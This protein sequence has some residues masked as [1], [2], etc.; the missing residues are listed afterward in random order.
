MVAV[1]EHVWRFPPLDVRDLDGRER[2]LP[3]DLDGERTLVILAFEQRQQ[4]LVDSWVPWLEEQAAADPGL[5]F[6]EVPTIGTGWKP[7]RGWIDGGM[8]RGIPDPVVRRRTLTAYVPVGPI[9]AELGITDTGDIWIF[10]V[11]RAGCVRWRGRGGFSPNS[12]AD[13][14]RALDAE[15]AG[16]LSAGQA[17][18]AVFPFEF[19]ERYRLVLRGLGVPPANRQVVITPE[20]FV[21]RFGRWVVDTPLANVDDA[22]ITGPY[23]AHR[24]IGARG[25]FA[26]RGATFGTTCAGGVCVQFHTPVRG[27]DPLGLVKHPGFAVTVAD[28]E[29]LRELLRRRAGRGLAREPPAGRAAGRQPGFTAE[30]A[31]NQLQGFGPLA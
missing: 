22:C 2:R 13:L 28:R 14:A 29:G 11:D 15:R 5:R 17:A 12:A 18:V 8:R 30:P 27:L 31:V 19:E 20:R 21:A 6:V 7:V 25:S 10:L 9:T 4:R 23:R 3:D 24:A 16:E 1:T 26:D